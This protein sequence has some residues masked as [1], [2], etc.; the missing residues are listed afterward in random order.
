MVANNSEIQCDVFKQKLCDVDYYLI[1]GQTILLEMF[2]NEKYKYTFRQIN[3]QNVL[4]ERQFKDR[5]RN[6]QNS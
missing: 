4:Y 5:R 3:G 6:N 2:S 1:I